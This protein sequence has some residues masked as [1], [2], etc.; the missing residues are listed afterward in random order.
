MFNLVD[1]NA[2]T[3]EVMP[4]PRTIVSGLAPFMTMESLLVKKNCTFFSIFMHN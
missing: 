1:L 3:T 4:N 2:E